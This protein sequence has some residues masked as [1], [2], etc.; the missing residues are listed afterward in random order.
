MIFCTI[1]CI[2][3]IMSLE[4]SEPERSFFVFRRYRV[5]ASQSPFHPYTAICNTKRMLGTLLR[6]YEK[7]KHIQRPQ[8][9]R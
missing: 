5:F 3:E 8:A 2:N 1:A 4:N 9:P 7:N 6:V